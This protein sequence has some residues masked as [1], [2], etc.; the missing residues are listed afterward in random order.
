MNK[1]ESFKYDL[2]ISYATTPDYRL[3][4]DLESFLE[5][6]HRLPVPEDQPLRPL[7]VCVDGSDFCL[8]REQRLSEQRVGVPEVI[9]SHLAECAELLVLCSTGARDSKWVNEEVQW[10]LE[11]RGSHA[12]R[13]AVTDGADPSH[14]PQEI[15]SEKMIQARL[16]EKLWYDFRGYRKPVPRHWVS[17]RDFEDN[18]IR[19]AADLLGRPA[20]EIQPVW[21]REQR[22]L[23]R[24]RTRIAAAVA[25]VMIILAIVATGF[26]IYANMQARIA[27]LRRLIAQAQAT[28]AEYPQRGV[29]L[30][31]EAV[32]AA[33]DE[34]L[35]LPAAQQ[36]LRNALARCGGAGLTGHSGAIT[37][38]A[39]SADDRWLATA[40]DDGTARL[41]DLSA[42]HPASTSIIL[43]GHSQGLTDLAISPN[44]RWLVT[45]SWDC[46][47]R[48]WDLTGPRPARASKTM[49]G[50]QGA[51]KH[52]AISPDS[53]WLVTAST[54]STC[55]LWELNDEDPGGTSKILPGESNKHWDFTPRAVMSLDSQWVVTVSADLTARVWDIMAEDPSTTCKVLRGHERPIVDLAITSDNRWLVSI[56]Y[57]GTARLWDL[58]ADAPSATSRILHGSAQM[59]SPDGRWLATGAV[60]G[61]LRFW[62]LKSEDPTANFRWQR[63]HTDK[64]TLVRYSP[65]GRWLVTIDDGASANYESIIKLWDLASSDAATSSYILRAHDGDVLGATFSPD[66][67]WVVTYGRRTAEVWNLNAPNPGAKSIVLRG[68]ED[69]FPGVIAPDRPDYIIATEFTSDSRTIIT[70][71]DDGS[72]RRWDVTTI[73]SPA[74]W[75]VLRGHQGD[76]NAVTLNPDKHLIVSGSYDHTVRV[77]DLTDE[78]PTA[79]AV[80][81]SDRPGF[82][83]VRN[84][85]GSLFSSSAP[86]DSSKSVENVAISHDGRWVYAR[87]AGGIARIWDLTSTE[88]ALRSR[89]LRR[90]VKLETASKMAGDQW[91]TTVSRDGTIQMWDFSSSDPAPTFVVSLDEA[92]SIEAVAMSPN[93]RWIVAG[94]ADGT[95]RMWDVRA[96][97]AAPP[98]VLDGHNDTIWDIAISTDNR[99]VATASEDGTARVWDLVVNERP[100]TVLQGHEGKIINVRISPD[101]R[102]LVTGGTDDRT[103]RVWELGANGP[104]TTP[105]V[106]RGHEGPIFDMAISPDSRWLA[107]GTVDREGTVRI[108]DL[109]AKDPTRTAV[110]VRTGDYLYTTDITH[111]SRW[112]VTGHVDGAIRLW[113]LRHDDLMAQARRKVGRNLSTAEWKTY[114]PGVPYRET[115]TELPSGHD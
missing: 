66:S 18:R 38:M 74:A 21:F 101:N 1:V 68:H 76:I 16:S 2:F 51:I 45:A 70:S 7:Q 8:P 63:G 91:L 111:D 3:V 93:H 110:A 73:D 56:G 69:S 114:F 89:V 95:A 10:F 39:I 32:R 106:L 97:A 81:L 59:I 48:V 102:W 85:I 49:R 44:S 27:N 15:F 46:T 84:L 100:S 34:S 60:D 11:H 55:R 103:A 71:S 31:A 52:L 112:L 42:P 75:Q 87:S 65:D 99:W 105:H 41:C 9:K 24:R 6:F 22:R 92:D 104:A 23:G 19:L 98:L 20:G 29:L 53:R 80:S 54:D 94:Y 28:A 33:S 14:N 13:V 77:W 115:F 40:S 78:D 90:D 86:A 5:S 64:I 57:T 25:T 107:T 4:R 36:A 43:R 26:G 50:H 62:D 61:Y 109:T 35:L 47:A 82:S 12:I 37:D 83:R 79:S 108:W 113:A 58:T 72:A 88:H 30:A 67:R 96:S 17:V